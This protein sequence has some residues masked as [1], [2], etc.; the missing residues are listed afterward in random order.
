MFSLSFET[1][2]DFETKAILLSIELTPLEIHKVCAFGIMFAPSDSD[3]VDS[4]VITS[5]INVTASLE[6]ITKGQTFRRGLE[7]LEISVFY[8]SELVD[9][10]VTPC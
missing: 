6:V 4:S 7:V 10:E 8:G 3:A 1:V 9:P 2:D 5:V